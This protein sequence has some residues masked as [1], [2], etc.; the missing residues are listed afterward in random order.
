MDGLDEPMRWM[1]HQSGCSDGLEG[2]IYQSNWLGQ[3]AGL[4]EH[5][6]Q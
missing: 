5:K 1:G 6:D 2:L 4:V 3:R